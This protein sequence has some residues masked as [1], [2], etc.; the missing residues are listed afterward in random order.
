ML[1]KESHEMAVIVDVDVKR[2]WI[3]KMFLWLGMEGKI[4]ARVC[5]KAER[6]SSWIF[7]SLY[8]NFSEFWSCDKLKV[9]NWIRWRDSSRD[10]IL[11]RFKNNLEVGVEGRGVLD[12][13]RVNFEL[14]TAFGGESNSPLAFQTY[15]VF[16]L[17]KNDLFNRV[18]IFV[19]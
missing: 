10:L 15:R 1:I 6:I 4:F 2:F 9:G 7:L 13:L 11:C 8:F 3:K 18:S 19:G 14:L 16:T 12:A 17:A 5:V